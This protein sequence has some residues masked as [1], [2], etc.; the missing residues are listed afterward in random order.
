MLKSYRLLIVAFAMLTVATGASAQNIL[1]NPG[2]ED[3]Y[4]GWTLFNNAYI[5]TTGG[6]PCINP[7]EGVYDLKFFGNFWGSFNVSGAFQNFP[8]APGAEWT[9]CCQSYICADDPM[10]GTGPDAFCWAI[11]K[12]VFFDASDTEIGGVESIIGDGTFATGVWNSNSPIFG[13]APAGTA[14]VQIL[15]L[16]LQPA[17]NY[18]GGAVQVDNVIAFQCGGPV[19][20]EEASW[21]AIKKASK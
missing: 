14:Y 5:E 16:Y 10:I 8:T 20:N 4:S 1:A 11:Q 2:F 7:Y 3:G 17:D 15:L 9:M 18:D 6:D 19:A 21:G 12:I 13:T